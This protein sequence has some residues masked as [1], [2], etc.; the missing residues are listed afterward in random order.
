MIDQSCDC[1]SSF[2]RRDMPDRK[3]LRHGIGHIPGAPGNDGAASDA[4]R[5]LDQQNAKIN[6]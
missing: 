5:I 2:G 1:R 6:G 3:L 4:G